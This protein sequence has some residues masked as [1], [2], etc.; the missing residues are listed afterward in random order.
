MYIDNAEAAYLASRI[1]VSKKMARSAVGGCAKHAHE[2]LAARY[3]VKLTSMLR[4]AVTKMA[5]PTHSGAQPV[6]VL[7]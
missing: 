2:E 5:V 1:R 6:A 3:Q 4:I 7:S